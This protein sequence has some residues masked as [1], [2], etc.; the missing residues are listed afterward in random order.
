MIHEITRNVTKWK[1]FV[2]VRVI[3]WIGFVNQAKRPRKGPGFG[4]HACSRVFTR[5]PLRA[6]TR[7]LGLAFTRTMIW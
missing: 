7:V 3:S 2:F 1:I 6:R 4:L 5:N